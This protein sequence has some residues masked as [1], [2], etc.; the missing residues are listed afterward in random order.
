MRGHSEKQGALFAYF[1]LE[2]LVPLEHPLRG[3]KKHVDRILEEMSANFDELYSDTGR[4]SIPPER[5]LK[6]KLLMAFFSIRSDRVF[7]EM[8]SYNFLFR[9]FLDMRADQGT[10]CQSN[11]SRFTTRMLET[12]ISACFFQKVVEIAHNNE[13]T[14]S[15]HMTVDG[16][17]LEAW[18]SQKSFVPKDD[19]GNKPGSGSDVNFRGQ[20]RKNDTHHSKTD[21]EARLM[22]K[23]KG[24]EAKL[25]FGGHALMENRNGLLMDI[26]VTD[27]LT[28]ET[29]ATK[30]LLEDMAE[31]YGLPKT[32]GADKGYHVS[33]FVRYLRDNGIAPHIALITNRK[34]PGLDGRTTRHAGYK[35]SQVI[36]KRVEEIF[37]WMKTYGGLAKSRYVGIQKNQVSAHI[38][39]A[40]YNLVR[41]TKLL[42]VV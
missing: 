4:P 34:T 15:D 40:A 37:G 3:V 22:R 14:S 29:E 10:L 16:T 35:V 11:F 30:R 32:L 5:L 26:L 9:W 28:T 8:L 21:P 24:K 31:R 23:G 6:A 1:D 18:A 38:V 41:L 27:A 13:L 17:L 12:E 33:S 42:P 7:C 36:R 20:K 19:S 2:E 25:C 39:G